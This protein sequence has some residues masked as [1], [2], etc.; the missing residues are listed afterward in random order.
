MDCSVQAALLVAVC[1]ERSMTESNILS[2][3]FSLDPF[4]KQK[5]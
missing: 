5:D 3:C 1:Y 2:S 4:V